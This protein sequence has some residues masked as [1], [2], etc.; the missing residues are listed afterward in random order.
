MRI[1]DKS[2]RKDWLTI[3][4]NQGSFVDGIYEQDTSSKI[5]ILA[6][7]QPF[8]GS[9]VEHDRDGQWQK[10]VLR[11]FSETPIELLDEFTFRDSKYVVENVLDYTCG[12][13]PHFEALAHE[14]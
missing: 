3:Y 5:N 11:I 9:T 1:P 14:I 7:I 6:H 10:S 12:P 2:I 13:M 4:R 8:T